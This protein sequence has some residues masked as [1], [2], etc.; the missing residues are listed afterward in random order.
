MSVFLTVSG[1]EQPSA[2][3]V[4]FRNLMEVAGPCTMCGTMVNPLSL[5]SFSEYLYVLNEHVQQISLEKD[6]IN[7]IPVLMQKGG[8]S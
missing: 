1:M 2:Y 8:C 7:V 5:S 3:Q 6:V 4:T